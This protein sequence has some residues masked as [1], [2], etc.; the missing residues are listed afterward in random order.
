MTWSY[1]LSCITTSHKDQV[2]FL[3]GD[4]NGN[5]KQL[6]D[7]EL[8]FALTY[9]GSVIGA[10]VVACQALSTLFSRKAD[11]VTGELRTMWSSVAR[12][13][14][15]RAQEFQNQLSETT[16]ASPYAG[17]VSIADKR[18]REDN[19]D[20]AHPSFKRDLTDNFNQPVSPAGDES[21]LLDG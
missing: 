14:A 7:E 10:A 11:T 8:A 19:A 15:A 4:T 2:R 9:G 18:E 12:A 17:G 3:I 5:D 6:Q 1:D 16:F 13:Y 20:R 21:S